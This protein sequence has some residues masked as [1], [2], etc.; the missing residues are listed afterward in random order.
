MSLNVGFF[1]MNWRCCV[2]QKCL[3]VCFFQSMNSKYFSD[4]TLFV[5]LHR[6][7]SIAGLLK[8][9]LCCLVRVQSSFAHFE[10]AGGGGWCTWQQ[11]SEPAYQQGF[12]AHLR[13]SPVL[14]C[15]SSHLYTEQSLLSCWS[16]EKRLCATWR[17]PVGCLLC[18][19]RKI[20]KGKDR[21]K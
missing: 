14:L 3:L 9:D 17:K 10:A 19:D 20:E 4:V 13:T 16:T 1:H 18:P 5:S 6:V 12:V 8:Q 21:K 11:S 7:Y 2:C 15:A